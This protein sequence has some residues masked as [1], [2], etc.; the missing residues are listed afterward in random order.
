ENDANRYLAVRD[1]YVST[2][3][4]QGAPQVGV[5]LSRW[6]RA[7]TLERWSTT[8][9]VPGAYSSFTYDGNF[10]YVM[11]KPPQAASI[12]LE[13]CFSDWPGHPD[14]IVT[15]DGMCVGSGYTRLRT[16]GWVYESEQLF[17]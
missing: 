1:V 12:K 13:E 2:G 6:S 8:A 10:G 11:T 7:S 17:T 16:I 5:E 9:M 15:E 3:N 4:P 14:R